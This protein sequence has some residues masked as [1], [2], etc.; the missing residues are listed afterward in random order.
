MVDLFH[1]TSTGWAPPPGRLQC[2]HRLGAPHAL[3]GPE[4][5]ARGRNPGE[6]RFSAAQLMVFS[7][8]LRLSLSLTQTFVGLVKFSPG[9]LQ[10]QTCSCLKLKELGMYGLGLCTLSCFDPC[11]KSERLGLHHLLWREPVDLIPPNPP[12]LP[13]PDD[14][15]SMPFFLVMGRS[16]IHLVRSTH[17]SREPLVSLERNRDPRPFRQVTPTNIQRLGD[18]R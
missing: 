8:R 7:Q 1:L 16:N 2:G 4:P 14:P 3:W 5:S 12:I 18:G 13:D 11:L 6:S 10:Q 9:C 15:G 17:V